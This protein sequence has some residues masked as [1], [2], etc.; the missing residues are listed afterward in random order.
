MGEEFLNRLYKD[1]FKSPEVMYGVDKRF[2]GNKLENIKNYLE[3]MEQLHDRSVE[4]GHIDVLKEFY[5]Q[6]YVIKK[7]DIP[8]AY[9]GLQKQIYLERGYGHIELNEFNKGRMA[10]EVI[11]EQR[12][13][14]EKWIDY[15]ISD[16]AKVYPFWAKY[17]AFQG[18]LKLGRYDKAKQQFSRRTKGT[19]TVFTEVN[20][21]ALS[22][23]IDFLIK[24]LNKEKIEDQEL[25]ALLKN[26][27]FEKI[28]TYIIKKL[29]N[30]EKEIANSNK[31]EWI[32]YLQGSDHM[33]LVKSLEG[34]GTGWCTAGEETAKSQL[35]MGDFYVYYSYDTNGKATIPRL[36]IRMEYGKIAEVRGVAFSQNI[37][38]EMEEVVDK[39]L[40]EFPDKDEYKEKVDDMRHLTR[41][42][43]NG[44][45]LTKEDLRFLYELDGT[46]K[47][48][49][50]EPDPR[51]NEIISKRNI[52]DDMNAAL[53][54][55]EVNNVN[56]PFIRSANGLKFPEE[57]DGNLILGKLV[58]TVG[59]KLPKRIGK[60]LDLGFVTSLNGIELPEYVGEYFSANCL[61]DVL[62][63]ILP[64]YVSGI[65]LNG[66]KNAS[67]LEFPD[68]IEGDV[69]LECLVSASG[70]RFPNNCGGLY[71]GGVLSLNGAK[72]PNV[73]R[74]DLDLKSIENIGD[75][76]FPRVIGGDLDLSNLKV[77]NGNVKLPEDVGGNIYINNWD[78][79]EYL[80]IPSS[81]KEK[82]HISM[83]NNLEDD[84]YGLGNGQIIR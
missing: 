59:L 8:D 15:L 71:L 60:S 50:Y 18:V 34:R 26:G 25:E 5:Y 68:Y 66:L 22:L 13:S 43:E 14:L 6:K 1:M 74:G 84:F 49:G 54:E 58:D 24:S 67:G 16:D 56:L 38:P 39:K 42:Y 30:N 78:I 55:H 70:I 3:R 11:E 45:N 83:V 69:S 82:M 9:Y 20:H 62:G 32:K 41:I 73:V 31:G 51:K 52:I 40:A 65:E 64:K 53:V 47:G 79:V 61:V 44:E 72:L 4:K 75:F 7:E 37:E 23:S 36:A 46:I 28:Y 29:S 2:I 57:V 48:F 77:I 27:S 80:E 76:E 81:L 35:A 17:W 19:T 33:P 21:E 12:Q 10:Q 63:L